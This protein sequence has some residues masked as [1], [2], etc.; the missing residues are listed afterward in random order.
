MDTNTNTQT[1]EPPILPASEQDPHSDTR[2][3]VAVRGAA[4]SN[5]RIGFDAAADDEHRHRGIEGTHAFDVAVLAAVEYAYAAG[6][7]A[8]F[9]SAAD[10]AGDG[11]LTADDV[12]AFSGERTQCGNLEDSVDGMRCERALGHTG[13][14]ATLTDDDRAGADLSPLGIAVSWM[15]GREEGTIVISTHADHEG[16]EET[17]ASMGCSRCYA[18]VGNQDDG[19]VPSGPLVW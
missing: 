11:V 5:A 10:P 1:H 18:A 4:L 2:V 6:F 7:A 16:E 9:Q 17:Y 8:G 13:S 3:P 12:M 19:G 15:W 14:H